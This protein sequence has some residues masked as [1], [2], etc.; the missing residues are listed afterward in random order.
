M[1]DQ[2][3][4]IL[5]T[6]V[7]SGAPVLI[8]VGAVSAAILLGWVLLLVLGAIRAGIRRLRA[9]TEIGLSIPR[10]FRVKPARAFR[11]VGAF[12]LD[13]PHWRVAKKDGTRDLRCRDNAV[14]RGLSVL[15]IGRWRLV[16][17]SVVRLY[18]FV[19]ALRGMGHKIAFSNEEAEKF[20]RINGQ[21]QLR[22]TGEASDGLYRRFSGDPTQFEQFCA[23]LYGC[24][25]YRVEVTPPV[26]DGGF[27]L[28]M[29]RGGEK[30]LVECKCFRPASSVGRPVLQ[31]LF[32]ANAVER[33]NHLILVT[34]ATFSKKAIGYAR[35]VGIELV[36]GLALVTLCNRVW[37]GRPP[38]RGATAQEAQLTLEDHLS[39]MPADIR[40]PR[41]FLG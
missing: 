1:L 6:F 19:I 18:D 31:K 35:D 21:A 17:R 30:I 3:L 11:E 10:G 7:E 27:D 4:Q 40:H 13:Y 22:W 39:R 32:G 36:D 14:V 8:P 38:V 26:A 24:L 15:E 16:S 9:E 34:T 23:K 25:G 29:F 37:G 12:L 2:V 33:A 41:T 28:R 20:N 5:R